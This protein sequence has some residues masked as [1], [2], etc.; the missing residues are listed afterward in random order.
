MSIQTSVH[1]N[2]CTCTMTSYTSSTV[3]LSLLVTRHAVLPFDRAQ[4]CPLGLLVQRTV[5][6]LPRD[7]YVP[8]VLF[9]SVYSDIPMSF[10]ICQQTVIHSTLLS[11]FLLL[12]N[13]LPVLKTLGFL[14]TVVCSS[15]ISNIIAKPIS[16][17]ATY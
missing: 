11:S 3:H 14:L 10:G 6:R 15:H 12:T 17:G 7:T 16:L 4:P 8:Y 13:A 9:A 2:S 1:P 5:L